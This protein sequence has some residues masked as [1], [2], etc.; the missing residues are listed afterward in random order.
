L[1]DRVRRVLA[2][3]GF[4]LGAL[5]G[6]ALWLDRWLHGFTPSVRGSNRLGCFPA[7]LAFA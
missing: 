2:A 6:G 7:R 4:F 3:D 1:A 5:L